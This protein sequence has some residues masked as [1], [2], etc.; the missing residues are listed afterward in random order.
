MRIEVTESL[1]WS[2]A[3]AQQEADRWNELMG[4]QDPAPY[5]VWDTVLRW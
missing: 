2:R 1:W 3:A 5:K 4:S